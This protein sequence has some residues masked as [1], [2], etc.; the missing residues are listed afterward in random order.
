M[1]F[2][3]CSSVI[4]YIDGLPFVAVAAASLRKEVYGV[5]TFAAY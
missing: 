2:V 5:C 1:C 4:E 3:D